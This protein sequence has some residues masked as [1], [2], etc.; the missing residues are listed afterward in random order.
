MPLG[1]DTKRRTDY[2]VIT[3][4]EALGIPMLDFVDAWGVVEVVRQLVEF[5]D[6][7]CQ[8][9]WKLLCTQRVT[10][11]IEHALDVCFDIESRTCE[12]L[13]GFEQR[14]LAG[15]LTKQDHLLQRDCSHASGCRGRC[16]T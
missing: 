8:S 10:V 5:A 13:A 4:L 3:D 14:A 9:N 1:L 6:T 16:W 2:Q 7:V 15:V 11:R 12:E